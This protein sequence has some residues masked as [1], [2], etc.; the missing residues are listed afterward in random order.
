MDEDGEVPTRLT[1]D[2]ADYMRWSMQW[3]KLGREWYRLMKLSPE[4]ARMAKETYESMA[5]LVSA[6]RHAADGL[7][8]CGVR[9]PKAIT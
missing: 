6:A 2:Q 8:R 7:E 9:P 1:P 3:A 4:L 5:A